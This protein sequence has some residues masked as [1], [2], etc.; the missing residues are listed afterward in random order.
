VPV[1]LESGELAPPDRPSLDMPFVA[2]TEP[3]RVALTQER[4]DR[5]SLERLER[6]F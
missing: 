5:V 1:D 6:D 4:R 2:G 3:E